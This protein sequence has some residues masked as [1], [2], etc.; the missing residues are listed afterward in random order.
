[1]TQLYKKN[2]AVFIPAGITFEEVEK[3]EKENA[4]LSNSVTELSNTKTELDNKV[5]EL[6]KQIEILEKENEEFLESCKDK[7]RQLNKWFLSYNDVMQENA[8]LK[9]QIKL[10]E[11][12]SDANADE[13]KELKAQEEIL[14]DRILTLQKTSGSSTDKINMLEEQ[15]EKL[16][17][18]GDFNDRK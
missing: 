1:M 12:V 9:E 6:E 2:G 7:D 16:K 8:E 10:I 14:L 18:K 11:S 17:K 5:T 13:N 15:I 4:D 3:I